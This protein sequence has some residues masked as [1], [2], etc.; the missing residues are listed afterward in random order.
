MKFNKYVKKFSN[1]SIKDYKKN[2]QL[3][4]SIEI[5]LIPEMKKSGEFICIPDK[6][7]K[8]YHIYFNNSKEERKGTKRNSFQESDQVKKIKVLIDYEVTSF[9]NLFWIVIVLGQYLSKN[10]IE[11]I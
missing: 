2:S 11:K 3:F 9:N 10:L 6:D 5:E 1:I 7:K 4:S 8:Y